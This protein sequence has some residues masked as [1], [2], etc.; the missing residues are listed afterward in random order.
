MFGLQHQAAVSVLWDGRLY[1]TAPRRGAASI[2][3]SAT[4][5]WSRLR[6]VR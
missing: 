4:S 1:V 5:K 6:T 2:P 3:Q